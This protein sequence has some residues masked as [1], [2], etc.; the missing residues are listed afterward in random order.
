MSDLDTYGEWGTQPGYGRVWVPYSPSGW[1]PYSQ[2]RWYWDP[3]FGWTW[4]STEPWGWLP[5]HCGLWDYDASFGWYWMPGMMGCG[6]W[7]ASLVTWYRGQDWIGWGPQQLQV[8]PQPPGPPRPAQ[9]GHGRPAQGLPG[10]GGPA[11]GQPGQGRSGIM[12]VVAVSDKDFQSGHPIT[13]ESSYRALPT[14][15]ITTERPPFQPPL[16]VGDSSPIR[17]AGFT[18]A[19]TRRPRKP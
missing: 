18:G 16:V 3:T 17:A 10:H 1:T 6:M 15:G 4:I 11:Q 13:P 8:Q 14:Q 9:P 12:S 19:R 2:G 7:H 5:Y